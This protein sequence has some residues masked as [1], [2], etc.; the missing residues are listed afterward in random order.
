[1]SGHHGMPLHKQ[2]Y[3]VFKRKSEDDS[4]KLA[5]YD[6]DGIFEKAESEASECNE[7]E[8]KYDEKVLGRR[9]GCECVCG[10]LANGD[11]GLCPERV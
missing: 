2:F 3:S 5:R 10:I 8:A 11:C 6:Y 9:R 7:T 1:M 4:C